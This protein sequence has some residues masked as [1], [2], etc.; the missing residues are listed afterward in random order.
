MEIL[1]FSSN[2]F[3]K[4]LQ[5]VFFTVCVSC[6]VTQH[7]APPYTVHQW[8]FSLLKGSIMASTTNQYFSIFLKFL[9]I[10]LIQENKSFIKNYKNRQVYCFILEILLYISLLYNVLLLCTYNTA[11]I[12]TEWQKKIWN[13]ITITYLEVVLSC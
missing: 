9:S 10:S 7:L 1:S 3:L 2:W 8:T 11:K 13:Q 4:H 5:C 6:T 12:F